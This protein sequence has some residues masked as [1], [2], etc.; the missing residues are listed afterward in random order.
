MVKSLFEIKAEAANKRMQESKN[1]E[2]VEV[3]QNVEQTTESKPESNLTAEEAEQSVAEVEYLADDVATRAKELGDDSTAQEA[4]TI[5]GE[6]EQ[7]KADLQGDHLDSNP[8]TVTSSLSPDITARMEQDKRRE[9]ENKLASAE[10]MAKLYDIEASIKEA[11]ARGD[12]DYAELET[13]NLF[14]H[15][16]NSIKLGEEFRRSDKP[17]E[18]V[19]ILRGLKQNYES[20]GNRLSDD[21]L[22]ADP[23]TQASVY[24]S[25]IIPNIRESE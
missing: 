18:F 15:L 25:Q 12:T 22:G 2:G 23:A 8:V 13:Q 9:T 5:A 7:A 16:E 10:A 11:N 6:A 24:R 20:N 3:G 4:A 14:T 19:E 21:R 17:N 1:P